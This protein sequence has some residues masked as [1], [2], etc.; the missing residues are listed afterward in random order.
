MAANR[1]DL[2]IRLMHVHPP[3]AQ[4]GHP[5]LIR[6]DS[7]L[8]DTE[9]LDLVSCT[10]FSTPL[11][12][13]PSYKALSYTWGDQ[14]ITKAILLDGHRIEVTTN[15]EAA[16]RHIRG[17]VS[18]PLSIWI[19]AICINQ[20][21]EA[22]KSEQV[23]R[24]RDIYSRADEVITWL[25]TSSDEGRSKLAMR[26][27]AEF[28]GRAKALNI[29]GTPDMLLKKVL[30]RAEG[31]PSDLDDNE[32]QAFVRDLKRN[33]SSETNPDYDDLVTALQDILQRAYWS[34]IW[35]VQ[36]VRMAA[37][38]NFMCADGTVDMAPLHHALRLLRNFRQWQLVKLGYDVSGGPL[39]H[40]DSGLQR[41]VLQTNPSNPIDLLKVSR[42]S[43]MPMISLLRRLQDFKA[44]DPRDR[45]FA[46]LGLARDAK[47]LGLKPNY[48]K[49][50]EQV[51][52]ELSRS[53]MRHGY[54]DVLMHCIHEPHSKGSRLKLQSWVRD[55]AVRTTCAPLQQRAAIQS[56]DSAV[57]TVL[58]PEFKASGMRAQPEIQNAEG[59]HWND[60][61]ALS[62]ITIG[63]VF[64]VG[65]QWREDEVGHWLR[66]HETLAQRPECRHS[67]PQERSRAIWRTAVA[68]QD[69]RNHRDKPRLSAQTVDRLGVAFEGV[70]LGS[71][72]PQML[73]QNGLGHYAE[74][75]H[76][77]GRG[78]RP[79]LTSSGHLAIGPEE[80]VVGDHIVIVLEAPVPYVLR[81]R[82]H[83]S[84][85]LFIGEAYVHDCMD[86]EVAGDDAVIC[87]IELH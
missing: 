20:K 79:F 57:R 19:D 4:T 34:R 81:P 78:R 39:A 33:L 70:P 64:R 54:F 45:V 82:D 74:E 51:Y 53:L 32:E 24:M 83:G 56:K 10:I 69:V 28:G 80:L 42:T 49:S 72:E 26:W 52:T 77:V 25:G 55:W 16:L 15:L 41:Q 75:I 63:Q 30:E 36:E 21:D 5:G 84:G 48:S 38:I 62:A 47:E 71:I 76:A 37:K 18:D 60:P 7:K 46:L 43:G 65:E 86:G 8:D 29:G 12:T 27:I 13:A 68:D 61:I 1:D 59:A 2:R 6:R 9:D 31:I 58:Q 73:V 17:S 85:F 3:T 40:V 66:S 50:C 14:N 67:N 23:G 44:S 35:I 22:E 11:A 87:R